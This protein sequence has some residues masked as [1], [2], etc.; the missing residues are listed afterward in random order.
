MIF[1]KKLNNAYKEKRLIKTIIK[2]LYP[3]VMGF[4]L[5]FTLKKSEI[6]I[7][8]TKNKVVDKTEL[9]LV[10]KIF[11]SYKIMKSEQN[12]KSEL[13]KPSS[14][15]QSHINE[16]YGTLI[17]SNNEDDIEKFMFFL[18]N[19]G[20]WERYTG[21]ESQNIIKKYN[22]NLFLRNFLQK[23]MFQGQ[24]NLWK[25]FNKNIDLANLEQPRF[26]NHIGALVE[27]KFFVTF[28]SFSSSIYAEILQNYLCKKKI[29]LWN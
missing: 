14:Y 25:F 28:A 6:K 29:Q 9:P 15:W 8:I 27:N 5:L 3:Y 11:K 23:E 18:Q 20:N 10:E 1:L 26:G 4:F 24:L 21:I 16:S 12:S 19:F 7:F 17:E 13:Y 22:K 2:K